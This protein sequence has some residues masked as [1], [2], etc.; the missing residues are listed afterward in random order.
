LLI[1]LDDLRNNR[2]NFKSSDSVVDVRDIIKNEEKLSLDMKRVLLDGF[3]RQEG[4]LA[5]FKKDLFLY[6]KF[7][8]FILIDKRTGDHYV[9][10]E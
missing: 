7:L 1:Y 9:I 3:I 10:F 4:N 2:L 5:Y 8:L 6:Q